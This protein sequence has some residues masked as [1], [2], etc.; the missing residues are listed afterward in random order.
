MEHLNINKN[1]LD[2]FYRLR[3][4]GEWEHFYGF[5]ME[6]CDNPGWLFKYTDPI[7]IRLHH[8]PHYEKLI[9]KLS[10]KH[11]LEISFL[12]LISPSGNN[13][14]YGELSIF[15]E[16]FESILLAINELKPEIER[17]ILEQKE[18]MRASE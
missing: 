12:I 1:I 3:C 17:E 2:D 18:E 8:S 6:S 11:Q 7:L 9:H 10:S 5:S 4:D 13:E 15:G 14:K 16:S